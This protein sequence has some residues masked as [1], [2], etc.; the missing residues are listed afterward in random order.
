MTYFTNTYDLIL[1][2]KNY[3]LIKDKLQSHLT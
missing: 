3:N 1:H 2:E